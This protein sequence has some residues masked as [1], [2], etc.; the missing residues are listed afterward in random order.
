VLASLAIE[1]A[2]K[3]PNTT[4]AFFYCKY[5]DESR[6][7]FLAVARGI[8]SQVLSSQR[9]N[10]D[11]LL[12]VDER[13]SCSGE[14]VLS[15]S[16][17]A[18]ELLE[19][20]ILSCKQTYIILDGL[21]ECNR[22]ERKELSTWF[23]QLVDVLPRKEMDSIRCLFV[24]QDDGYARKDL[25]MLPSIKLTSTSNKSDIEMYAKVWHQRIEEK[26]GTLKSKGLNVAN[27]I[28][29]RAQGN[30]QIFILVSVH[31]VDQLQECF[32]SQNWSC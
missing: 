5:G 26:F 19:T 25:S 11:L 3:L 23:R 4:V 30:V 8:L 32:S 24:S 6:N 2:R 21:D 7:S 27:I 28:T 22:D 13:A 20:V 9:S 12:Y 10:D 16:K 29:A 17:L 14:T 15:S 31:W 1:E 18:K